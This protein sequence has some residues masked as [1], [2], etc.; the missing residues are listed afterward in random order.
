MKRNV[1]LFTA[2]SLVV[3]NM[4]G[5]GILTTSGLMAGYLPHSGYVFLC[6]IVGGLIAMSGAL[7]YTELATR[8]PV[9]GGEYVYLKECFHPILGFL[10]GWTSFFVGFSVPIAS[11]ALGFIEY[12]LAGINLAEQGADPLLLLW[13]KKGVAVLLILTFTGVH[14]AGVRLGSRIQNLLTV[15]KVVMVLGLAVLGIV[16]GG[17]GIS[18]FTNGVDAPLRFTAFGTAMV[19][20]MFSYSGWNASAYIAG[21]VKRPARTLLVSM[22]A[23]TSVV[24]ILYLS[25]NVFIF[26]VLP[27]SELQGHITVLEMASVRIFGNW[28][29]NAVGILVGF[30]LLSSLSAFV[31]LGPRVYYAMAKDRLF[32]PFAA[33]LHQKTGVP[34]RSIVIQGCIASLMVIIGSFEQLLIYTG[35]ALHLFP[36]MAVLGLLLARKRGLGDE[37][38]VRIRGGPL[39]PLF[40]LVSSLFIM[41][42][43]AMNRPI[44]SAAA[45]GTVLAGI[46]L[47]VIWKWRWGSQ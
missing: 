15:A 21:E 25:I 42:I 36:W 37:T 27:Y 30:A 47:Y 33:V 6:W 24:M 17:G 45:L 28:M 14:Y 5:A 8:M 44:E 2:G 34:G 7:C 11:S 43:N 40:F 12:I 20:V 35:F 18:A 26:S 31:F 29:G 19:L 10:T 3:A 32:F 13:L 38:A 22:V 39:V 4:V 46:P 9:V 1:N 23:G 16:F 41:V